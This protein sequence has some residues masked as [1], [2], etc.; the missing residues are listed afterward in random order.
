MGNKLLLKTIA[1]ALLLASLI[2]GATSSLSADA[3]KPTPTPALRQPNNSHQLFLPF[4]IQPPG[5]PPPS[6]PKKGAGL[7]YQDCA[8]ATA[9]GA[10][11]SYGW[12]STPPDCADI[13][14]VPMIWGASDVNVNL[15]GNS[16][17][18]LGFNEPDSANQ[19]NLSPA[20]AA[21]LWRQIEQKHPS[22]KLVAPAPSGAAPN[23]LVDFRNAYIAAYGAPPRLDALAVHCY[24][25]YAWQC[26]AHTQQFITWANSW[27]AAEVWV[28]EFSFS[29]TAPSNP[30]RSIQEANTFITWM[31]GQAQVRR[32]AW[33]AS[34]IQ[35]NEWW[36][37]P[38]FH[39]PLVDWKSGEL[40]TYGTM[41]VPHR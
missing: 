33:F 41:Y 4:I 38:T 3:P 8:T 14:N 35:G 36:S 34:Q 22:R 28:T 12:A 1:G 30:T 32:Y 18:I 20:L 11:W 27:E 31:T 37:I 15:G 26:T 24:A 6:A 16:E 7:T 19:A 13:E 39:T 17:W 23:W 9:V 2:V 5:V 21:S 10:V 29:P 40:T 25:W